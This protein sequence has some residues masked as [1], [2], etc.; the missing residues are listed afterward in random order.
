MM[1][2]LVFPLLFIFLNSQSVYGV[3]HAAAVVTGCV[4]TIITNSIHCCLGLDF[5]SVVTIQKEYCWWKVSNIY[6][7]NEISNRGRLQE[8]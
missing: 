4:T 8:V 5:H 7:R 2:S 6:R 1:S 3:F